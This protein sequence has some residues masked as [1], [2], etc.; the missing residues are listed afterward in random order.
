M[1]SMFEITSINVLLKSLHACGM[2]RCLKKQ[3]NVD[4]QSTEIWGK[5]GDTK[6]IAILE[7]SVLSKIFIIFL[8]F[9]GF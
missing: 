5:Y 8:H 3:N 2:P 9:C 6:Q 7:V 4:R 1:R